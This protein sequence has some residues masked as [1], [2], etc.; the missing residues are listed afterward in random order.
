MKHR[1]LT[2]VIFMTIS[3]LAFSS[4]GGKAYTAV[5]PVT[6]TPAD[7]AIY[8][9]TSDIRPN[10]GLYGNPPELYMISEG[11]FVKAYEYRSDG[12]HRVQIIRWP[13]L[14]YMYIAAEFLTPHVQSELWPLPAIEISDFGRQVAEEFLSQFDS[15]FAP[16]PSAWNWLE[17]G[18][19][20][21][22]DGEATYDRHGN[23]IPDDAP[24]LKRRDTLGNYVAAYFELFDLDYNGIPDIVIMFVQETHQISSLY[25]FVDEE[26][27]AIASDIQFLF[28]YGQ[29]G[30]MLTRSGPTF[31]YFDADGNIEDNHAFGVDMAI[32]LEE[33]GFNKILPLS[34]LQD[35]IRQ[36]IT[37]GWS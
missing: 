34:E 19:Y 37:E 9:V 8:A 35:A 22:W 3:V 20:F 17:Y 26:Y 14:S 6:S 11:T 15:I 21:A 18:P 5:Q 24:F 1:I 10:E 33:Q 16:G 12:W 29:Y 27:T 13:E 30:R 25:R 4:C 2:V 23:R 36:S 7:G 28:Y 32:S 31:R